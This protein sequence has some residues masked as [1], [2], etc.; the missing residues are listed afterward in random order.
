MIAGQFLLAANTLT[1]VY[2]ASA[3]SNEVWVEVFVCN[4][5]GGQWSTLDIVLTQEQGV[6]EDK[7]YLYRGY[8]LRPNETKHPRLLLQ[9]NDAIA[10]R[11][12]TARVSVTVSAEEIV[13]PGT[14]AN[15]RD[16]LAERINDLTAELQRITEIVQEGVS[17]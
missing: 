17:V 9:A 12:T 3:L 15:V 5:D 7:H 2:R 13:T 1:E 10:V 6:P 4:Q 8:S 16:Q 14:I 11:A